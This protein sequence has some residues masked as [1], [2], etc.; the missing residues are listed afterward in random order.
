MDHS[1][2]AKKIAEIQY[3]L[4]EIFDEDNDAIQEDE[5][6]NQILPKQIVKEND[7]DSFVSVTS[8]MAD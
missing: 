2:I 4:D 3:E 1:L 6:G 5:L 7:D 8:A